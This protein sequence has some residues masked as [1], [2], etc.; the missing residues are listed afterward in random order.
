MDANLI[1]RTNFVSDG[2]IIIIIRNGG[3]L[4]NSEYSLL[5]NLVVG[6]LLRNCVQTPYRIPRHFVVYDIII[7][8][9]V[10]V[11]K[12]RKKKQYSPRH[13]VVGDYNKKNNKKPGKNNIVSDTSWSG[14]IIR[15]GAKTI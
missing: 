10:R 8:D 1:F 4:G 13:F 2:L 15:N 6:D 12:R 5:Y 7:L 11:D 9:K 3:H 14:T